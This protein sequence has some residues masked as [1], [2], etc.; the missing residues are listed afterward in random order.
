MKPTR[1]TFFLAI[2][3]LFWFGCGRADK[4]AA[5]PLE[6]NQDSITLTDLVINV[7]A[8]REKVNHQE[9]FTVMAD[10]SDT[11]Y[12]G[13]DWK[14]FDAHLSSLV[15]SA[16]FH[17]QFIDNH[18]KIAQQIDDDLKKGKIVWLVD[19]ISPFGNGANPWCNCQDYP[20]EYWKIITLVDLKIDNEKANFSWTWGNGFYYK[21]S[22][23]KESGVW[24]ISY[25]EGF[26]FNKYLSL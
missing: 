1:I 24:K 13:I 9:D 22:A 12:T 20:N 3:A 8:W 10:D 4:S 11:A 18:K 17:T 25:L 23:I 7:Y 26:D 6:I 16:Y 19:D 2:L 15:E 21:A 14:A 5:A